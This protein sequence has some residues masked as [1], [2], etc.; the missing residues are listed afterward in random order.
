MN[1][2]FDLLH[3]HILAEDER[4]TN[5]THFIAWV[6]ATHLGQ[7][8]GAYYDSSLD[9]IMYVIP[10]FWDKWLDEYD[11]V[12]LDVERNAKSYYNLVRYH[13]YIKSKSAEA[14]RNE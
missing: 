11:R 13:G 9:S 1:F 12:K 8:R 4:A 6:G 5:A 14:K 2:D 10:K 7:P 3:N